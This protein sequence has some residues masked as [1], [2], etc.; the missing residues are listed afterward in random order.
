[1]LTI[2]GRPGSSAVAKVM[3]TLGETGL[4][5]VRVD[6]GGAF[7][8]ND[9]PGFRAISP[10]GRIPAVR[11]ANGS[12]LFESNAIVRHLLS[13]C[14]RTDLLAPQGYPRALTESWMEWGHAFQ[15]AVSD[16]RKALKDE[17][18]CARATAK[19]RDAALVLETQ[20]TG[21]DFVMGAGFGAAD[22]ALGVWGHRLMRARESADL[23]A[24][25][26]I[27]AWYGRLRERPAYR[28]HVLTHVS[29]RKG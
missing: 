29:A 1:M 28:E 5:F 11:F 15:S 19:A 6:W 3:W 12:S 22:L 17:G 13:L 24:L 14:G 21:R 4:P 26:A 8:G 18:D 9:D 20:L 2:W 23:G 16:L 10:A 25:P 7:G 27:E